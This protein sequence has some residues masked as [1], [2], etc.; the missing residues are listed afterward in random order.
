MTVNFPDIQSAG[1]TFIEAIL[2]RDR[3]F[4]LEFLPYQVK[5]QSQ[6]IP[7]PAPA[8]ERLADFLYLLAGAPG[9]ETGDGFSQD[10][11]YHRANDRY[12]HPFNRLRH[13]RR[14]FFWRHLRLKR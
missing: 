3:R 12:H 4:P 13:G 1:D 5:E 2:R 14:Q 6:I 11:N 8:E 7:E 9:A 10:K